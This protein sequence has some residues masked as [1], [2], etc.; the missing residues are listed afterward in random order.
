MPFVVPEASRGQQQYGDTADQACH[1]GNSH[2]KI[3]QQAGILILILDKVGV[4]DTS[5]VVRSR[6]EAADR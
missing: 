2:I 5:Y 6:E 3:L 4:S 1:E